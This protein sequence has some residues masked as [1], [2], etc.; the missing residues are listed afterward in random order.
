MLKRELVRLLEEDAEFRDLA[1]AKLGIAELA[2]GLQ[3]LT[4]VLEGLAAEI[5]EQNAITKALAEACRNSSSDIAALKSLAEKEVEA[6]GTLAKIVEQVAER[7]ERGQAEAASSIG[8]KVV[9]ATEAVR[10][11]DE[12]LRRLIAT[13]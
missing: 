2:Q 4:Q 5:R 7:L 13:I 9:E 1:R 12:T 10:K 11:L 3:R 6:I 8:A